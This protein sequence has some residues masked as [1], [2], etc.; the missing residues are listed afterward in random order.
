MPLDDPDL[1]ITRD[2]IIVP[3]G[4][5]PL[6]GPGMPE[7]GPF[8]LPHAHYRRGHGALFM[9]NAHQANEGCDSKSFAEKRTS[10]A[11]PTTTT[12]P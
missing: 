9:D 7:W 10:W 12:S 6:V 5:G 3:K 2:S 11:T 8:P 1:D 4:A